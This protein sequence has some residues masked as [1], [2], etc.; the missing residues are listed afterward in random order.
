[1]ADNNEQKSHSMTR[2][3]TFPTGAEE[4]V[5]A[6]CGRWFIMTWPPNYKRIILN[7][8]DENVEHTGGTVNISAQATTDTTGDLANDPYL[9]LWG[10]YL[11]DIDEQTGDTQ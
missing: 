5:C 10:K 8:G 2:V 9:A 3:H 7:V 11:E 1:M 6:D 4:Y